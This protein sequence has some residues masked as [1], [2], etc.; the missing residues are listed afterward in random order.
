MKRVNFF[1][2]FTSIM[3]L[4][5]LGTLLSAVVTGLVIYIGTIAKLYSVSLLE[6]LIYGALISATDPVGDVYRVND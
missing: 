3:S 1:K 2:N 4:A 6:C 5:F